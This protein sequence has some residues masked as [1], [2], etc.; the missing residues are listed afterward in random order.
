MVKGAL[1]S[2]SFNEQPSEIK[3]YFINFSLFLLGK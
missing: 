3:S 1:Y 2:T